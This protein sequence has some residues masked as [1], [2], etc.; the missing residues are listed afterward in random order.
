MFFILR[1]VAIKRSLVHY[2]APA[3]RQ[4][5][6]VRFLFPPWLRIAASRANSAS[7][8]HRDGPLAER[9]I[10][11]HP[12]GADEASS[13]V[14]PHFE[15]VTSTHDAIGESGLVK[16]SNSLTKG[17]RNAR[18]QAKP[19]EEKKDEFVHPHP[20]VSPE[21]LFNRSD[22]TYV[23]EDATV[24]HRGP[25]VCFFCGQYWLFLVIYGPFCRL[26]YQYFASLW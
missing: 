10:V 21:D 16:R 11:V 2:P 13:F 1:N 5:S 9:F 4:S 18:A 3:A 17:K 24:G 12:G 7:F 25:F 20:S 15:Y 22:I 26:L 6:A 14:D 19:K 8:P 23:L